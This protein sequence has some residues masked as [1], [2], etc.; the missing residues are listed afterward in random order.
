M[1]NKISLMWASLTEFLY[2][3]SLPTTKFCDSENRDNFTS[4][5]GNQPFECLD[6]LVSLFLKILFIPDGR[7][8]NS[9]IQYMEYT[10]N[11]YKFNISFNVYHFRNVENLKQA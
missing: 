8:Y 10:Q 11:F 1:T 3:L 4:L 6:L 9:M 7:T 2:T 5:E